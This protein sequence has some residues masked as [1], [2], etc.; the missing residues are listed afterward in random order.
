MPG[1][2]DHMMIFINRDRHRER[3]RKKYTYLWLLYSFFLIDHNLKINLKFL[4][5]F[6]FK[7]K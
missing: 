2:Y 4:S 5:M 7:Q 6:G 3:E 1:L